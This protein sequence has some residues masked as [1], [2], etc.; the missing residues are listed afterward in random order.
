MNKKGFTLVELLAVIVIMG[1][2]I[3]IAVPATGLMKDK[4]NEYMLN[5]KIELIEK[6]AILYGEDNI[7]E[8]T[9]STKKYNG[10]NCIIIKV[11]NLVPEY[12]D[13]ETDSTEGYIEDVTNKG[14]YLDEDN[15]IIY[16]VNKTIKTKYQTDKDICS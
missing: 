7:N 8:V 11:K 4:I 2:I 12:L 10:N 9:D 15:I 3:A 14:Q 13:S 1:I 6:S 5:K 16:L